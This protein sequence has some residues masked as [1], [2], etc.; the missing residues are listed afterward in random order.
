MDHRGNVIKRVDA[1]DISPVGVQTA[2]G[3]PAREGFPNYS[4]HSL[5]GLVDIFEQRGASNTLYMCDDAAVWAKLAPGANMPPNY[6][7]ERTRE[8]S[9]VK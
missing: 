5:K 9:S 1:P 2:D 6:R 7:I 8:A 3:A 4:T